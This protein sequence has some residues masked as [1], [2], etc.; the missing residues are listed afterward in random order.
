MC[1]HCLH[2]I[3]AEYPIGTASTIWYNED[4]QKCQDSQEL[5]TIFWVSIGFFILLGLSLFLLLMTT[6]KY[7]RIPEGIEDS[8]A[9]F[10]QLNSNASSRGL[11]RGSSLRSLFS[12]DTN[13]DAPPPADIMWS[14]GIAKYEWTD[15]IFSEIRKRHFVGARCT[16]WEPSEL[17]KPYFLFS[18]FKACA[19]MTA[20]FDSGPTSTLYVIFS[21]K[22]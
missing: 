8:S 20:H 4:S 19:P 18:P 22:I 14:I 16:G 15:Y 21:W 9:D 12:K 17:S 6:V 5:T 11:Q 10:S 7:F 3:E 2:A 13:Q 1:D